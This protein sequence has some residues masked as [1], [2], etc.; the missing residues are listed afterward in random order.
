[1]TEA[2]NPTAT[3]TCLLCHTVAPTTTAERLAEGGDWR[4]PNCH[5]NWSAARLAT[6][7][8]YTEYSAARS[9]R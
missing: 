3:A 2:I 5:Q 9:K 8:A 6:V 7:A 1:M 4:C